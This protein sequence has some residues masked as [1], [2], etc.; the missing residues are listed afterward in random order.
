M[1]D[2]PLSSQGRPD[3]HHRRHPRHPLGP[4]P[5][6]LLYDGRA[7]PHPARHRHHRGPGPRDPRPEG[8]LMPANNGGS[9]GPRF[10]AMLLI[11][12]GIAALVYG[13]FSYADQKDTAR[14]GDMAIS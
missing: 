7:D 13:N 12:A 8:A 1:A 2:A 6:D 11:A 3:A 14:I 4:R 5:P 10:G 9:N